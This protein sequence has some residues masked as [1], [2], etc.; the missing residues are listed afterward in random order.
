MDVL[1]LQHIDKYLDKLQNYP[2]VWAF[3]WP[4]FLRIAHWFVNQ[5]RETRTEIIETQAPKSL[6][7]REVTLSVE[8]LSFSYSTRPNVCVLNNVMMDGRWPSPSSTASFAFAFVSTKAFQKLRPA[9]RDR[10]AIRAEVIGRLTES[11]SWEQ[12]S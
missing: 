1:S 8:D 4:R 7:S 10:G 2:G 6:S 11:R 12:K 9:F 5:E 3:W